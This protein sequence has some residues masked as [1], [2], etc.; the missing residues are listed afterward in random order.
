M[1]F[2]RRLMNPHRVRPSSDRSPSLIWLTP[3][4]RRSRS[5]PTWPPHSSR[6][7]VV[8]NDTMANVPETVLR[9]RKRNEEWAAKKA[10]AASEVRRCSKWR[11]RARFAASRVSARVNGRLDEYY[12]TGRTMGGFRRGNGSIRPMRSLRDATAIRPF[13]R[14]CAPPAGHRVANGC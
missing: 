6:N 5:S 7:L 3:V 1:T 8:T 4:R 13:P 2:D 10:A 11:I 14:A 12:V 9:K